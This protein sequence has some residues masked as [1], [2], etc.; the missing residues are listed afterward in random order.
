MNALFDTEFSKAIEIGKENLEILVLA[1]AWCENINV[2]KGPLGT[3]L[4]EQV[5]GLP[6]SGGSLRCDFAKAPTSFAMSL[7]NTALGFYERNCIGCPSR[8][9]TSQTVH[10]GT[11]AEAR[12]QERERRGAEAEQ[13]RIK[14][15]EDRVKR[16]A[17]RRFEFGQTNPVSQSILDL[18]D[19][20]DTLDQD[21]GAE[22]LLL[23]HAQMAPGDFPD[24]LVEHLAKE[25]MDIG[26]GAFLE[27]VIAIFERQGRPAKKT[28]LD[29]AFRA[30]ADN[31]A[32]EAAGLVIASHAQIFPVE[33]SLLEPLVRLAA[34][35]PDFFHPPRVNAEPA[36]LL[37]FFDCDPD[38][39]VA[40]VGGMLSHE[41]VWKRADAAHAA[42]KMIAARPDAGS[43]LLSALLGSLEYE[44]ISLSLGDP[45][46]AAQAARVVAD[47]FVADP[48]TTDLT[49]YNR[50]QKV[51]VEQAKRLW[52]CYDRA[53]PSRFREPVPS[54]VTNTILHRALQLLKSDLD[55]GL[56]LEVSETLSNVCSVQTQI[57]SLSIQHLVRL[58]SAWRSRQR[59]MESAQE[60]L[61]F[62]SLMA[63]ESERMHVSGIVSRLRDALERVARQAPDQYI[64]LMEDVDIISTTP[65][66]RAFLIDVLRVAVNNQESFCR[67]V[68]ILRR[69]LTSAKP[70]IRASA[71]RVVGRTA[72][73]IESIPPEFTER[74]VEAFE[75]DRLDVFIGAIHAARRVDIPHG[76]KPGLI[77]FLVGFAKAYGDGR[78][79]S[80]DVKL[81][82]RLALNLSEGESYHETVVQSVIEIIASLPSGEAL[83]TLPALGLEAHAKWPTAALNALRLDSNP[84]YYYVGDSKREDLLQAL[85]R[86][87]TDQLEPYLDDLE[88]IARQ[89]L[90]HEPRWVQSVIDLLTVHHEHERAAALAAMVAASIP[91]T[92]EMKPR[93]LIARQIAL[94]HQANAARGRRD[95]GAEER[96]L[97]EWSRLLL[98]EDDKGRNSEKSSS[99]I[100]NEFRAQLD[101]RKKIAAVLRH[102]EAGEHPPFQLAGVAE[103]FLDVGRPASPGDDRWALAQALRSL[104]KAV[105][106]ESSVEAADANASAFHEAAGYVSTK[107]LGGERLGAWSEAVVGTLQI[108]A[109]LQKFSDVRRAACELQGAPIT[110][111]SAAK[112]TREPALV[113]QMSQRKSG[114][115]PTVLLNFKL[116][117]QLASWPMA[118][119]A[120]RLYTVK[121]SAVVDELP[122]DCSKIK[123]D[124]ECSVPNTVLERQ[125]F[126]ISREGKTSDNGYLIARA[127]IPPNSGVDLT[128]IVEI[129]GSGGERYRA[130]VVGQRSLRI[131]TF[132]PSV[133]G[134][135]LPM[136]AQRIVELLGELDSRIPSLPPGD[137]LNLIHLLDATTRF[138]A[139]ADE[140]KDLHGIDESG[141]Q[142]RLKQALAMDPKIGSR[143][144]EAPKLGKGKTDL[145]LERIVDELKVSRT[146]IN[147][148]KAAGLVSQPTHYASAGDCPISI[149][150]ILDVSLKTEPPGIQS[151]YMGWVY[152]S[153]HGVD[154]AGIPSMV[155]VII[156]PIGFPLPSSWGRASVYSNVSG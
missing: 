128:P 50:I 117:D 119:Q 122:E 68:P 154:A 82:V 14:A 111:V 70:S 67:V 71:L 74:V 91:E 96:A 129:H 133:L 134:A 124:W 142:A 24:A 62:D 80:N 88:D 100:P 106:W 72:S 139:I 108:L 11:W 35:M 55:T 18:I 85:T 41:D 76:A 40:L 147:F 83:E 30:V 16:V 87:P 1:S 6:I 93:R 137:R 73:S 140:Q 45:F 7:V 103:Q 109:H 64:S 60:S 38:G 97:S 56:L 52:C 3:G 77:S 42:E 23:K 144:R 153:I 143:I 127:E 98:E 102:I 116:D 149:L 123:I 84:A 17:V 44:D 135:G 99:E 90:P 114:P 86:R 66:D 113:R 20:V 39:A 81:A 141:F 101:I 54:A 79:Y 8:K 46:A 43:L 148:E 13:E 146:A 63:L 75:T 151:N 110:F 15:E 37:R 32:C 121:A 33:E 115:N 120:A 58:A 57:G 94:G 155:A 51:E 65:F 138:A 69:A 19:R 92:R 26:N 12:I 152:P 61:N 4:L 27:A 9:P 36:A 78:L 31:V 118:L 126:H 47:I 48:E 21:L 2:T 145:M 89:R 10:L 130:N 28:M 34:G 105:S 132:M 95:V 107:T 150:T 156:I 5:T 53:C 49:L 131:N 22:E 25:A 136:V 29:V 104:D 59:G 112:P 125:G